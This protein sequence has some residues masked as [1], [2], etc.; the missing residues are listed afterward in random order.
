[1]STS[2][3]GRAQ[4]KG[5]LCITLQNILALC[6]PKERPDSPT[7]GP[8]AGMLLRPEIIE[9]AIKTHEE[10]LGPAYKIFFSPHG[11]KL[12]QTMLKEFARTL[13]EKKHIMLLPA[14]YEG[15]DARVEEE[16]ADAI[17]SVGDFVLMGGDIPA[18]TLLEG[19]LR[20]VPGVVGREESVEQDSFSG[21]LV[22]YPEYTEP[23]EWHGKRVPDI[24]RSGNHKE[25]A[26]WRYRQALERTVYGHFDWL[27]THPISD[28]LRDDAL[29]AMPKHYVALMH[30]GVKLKDGRVGTS[31]VTS[32]DLHD[33]ARSCCTY[34]IEQFF[35]VT[36]LKDQQT[37]VRTLMDFWLNEGLQYNAHRFQAMQRVVLINQLDEAIAA[38]E[39]TTGLK[40]LVIGTSAQSHDGVPMVSYSDQAIVWKHKRPVLILFGTAFGMS[41]ALIGRCD[42]LFP[43]IQ[44]FSA[45]NHLSVRSAAAIVLD[46]WLSHGR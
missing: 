24:I 11:K 34:G 17:I 32:I 18:M 29:A 25:I 20:Y 1:M 5:D 40:P 3:I 27:R 16:Y 39:K 6:A 28:G 19:M 7:Y 46:R 31:S 2:L 33:I 23:L 36:P 21:P 9:R 35:V 44:G 45:F 26:Q 37:I 38:I 12:T 41:D 8:G 15:M 43:T 10:R 14:R 30:D 4:E 13:L 42:Y 22:D